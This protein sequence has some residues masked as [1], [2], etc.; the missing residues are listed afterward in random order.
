[1]GEDYEVQFIYISDGF[2]ATRIFDNVHI[3]RVGPELTPLWDARI[4]VAPSTEH[5]TSSSVERQAS[6]VE[7][8]GSDK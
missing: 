3:F 6:S 7:Q 2:M 1:M 4:G 8:R 5:R